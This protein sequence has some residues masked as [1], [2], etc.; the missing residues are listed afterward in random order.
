MVFFIQKEDVYELQNSCS[1]Q[2]RNLITKISWSGWLY[3]AESKHG[4]YGIQNTRFLKKSDDIFFFN[5]KRNKVQVS[6][7]GCLKQKHEPIKFF[8]FV[9]N[10]QRL[11]NKKKA[12]DWSNLFDDICVFRLFFKHFWKNKTFKK[13][14]KKTKKSLKHYP[15]LKKME[16]RVAC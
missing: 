8:F 5:K 11:L 9:S 7:S 12:N 15:F 1:K 6:I 13:I 16:K 14:W 4:S 3:S 2:K 10:N